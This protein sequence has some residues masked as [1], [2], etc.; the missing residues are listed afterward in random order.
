MAYLTVVV[1]GKLDDLEALRE[2]IDDAVN[3]VVDEAD[4]DLED[5]DNIDV[6]TTIDND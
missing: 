3:K 5:G 6:K 4:V 2:D 1:T